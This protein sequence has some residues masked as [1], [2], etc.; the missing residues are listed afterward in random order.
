[1]VKAHANSWE[2]TDEFWKREWPLVPQ[3]LRDLSKQYKRAAGAGRPTMPPQLCSRQSCM[4]CAP[5]ANGRHCLLS[6]LV[7]PA[8]SIRNSW[9]GPRPGFS[10]TCGAWVW[11]SMTIAKVSPNAGRVLTGPCSRRRWHKRQW[12]ATRRIGG[13]GEVHQTSLAGGRA[14]RPVVPRRDGSQR[15]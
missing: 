2:V 14:W 6:A 12:R 10:R 3:P 8:R 4:Y 9:C 15:A 11:P 5:A 7:A 13:G 1:M